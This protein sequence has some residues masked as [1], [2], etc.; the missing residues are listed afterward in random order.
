MVSLNTMAQ[1]P[2]APPEDYLVD[3]WETDSGLPD[4]TV[5]SI[6]QTPDGYLWVGTLHGCLARFDGVRFVN[7]HPGNTPELP[8][9][10]VQGLRVDSEGTLWVGFVEGSLFSYRDRQFHY[11][12]GGVRTAAGWLKELV[13]CHPDRIVMSSYAGGLFQ[14]DRNPAP[15]DGKD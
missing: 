6:A 5:T 3:V 12:R 14:A 1:S 15:T 9:V 11:E 7:F 10:E 8:S 2:A 4:S 13:S